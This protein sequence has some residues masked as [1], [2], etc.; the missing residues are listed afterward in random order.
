MPAVRNGTVLYVQEP[1][2]DIEPGVHLK[3]VEETIDLDTIPLN[4]GVLVK[5][6]ALSSDP[7]IRYR[8]RDPIIPLFCPPI[9]LGTP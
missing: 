3:Y 4:G 8:L 7:Y 1:K 6:L 5:T 9:L 2:D